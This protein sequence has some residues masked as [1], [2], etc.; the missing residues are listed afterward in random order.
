MFLID[1]SERFNDIKEINKK[2][3]TDIMQ[4]S[5]IIIYEND[6][7]GGTIGLLFKNEKYLE[8]I[9]KKYIEYIKNSN[10]L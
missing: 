8:R 10:I 3:I 5:K 1:K 2:L 6:G 9:E 7:I 4:K